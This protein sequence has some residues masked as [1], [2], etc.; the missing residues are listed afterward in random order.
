MVAMRSLVKQAF[1]RELA[2]GREAREQADLGSAIA[3]FERAHILGQRYLFLHFYAH[4]QLLRVAVQ[5][6]DVREALGQLVRLF[7][8]LP[9]YLSGWVPKGNTG[10]ANVSA[11]QPMAVPSDLEP[12]VATHNIAQAVT[13]RA[14]LLGGAAIV[15]WA[16]AG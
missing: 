9:G 12:L 1:W 7:A 11:L 6:N 8:V 4:W 13:I 14:L 16:F 2:L 10:S 15:Y 3:H 5:R